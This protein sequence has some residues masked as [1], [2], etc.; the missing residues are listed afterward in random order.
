MSRSASDDDQRLI[1]AVFGVVFFGV[2]HDGMKIESLIP[3]VGDGPNRFL[4]ESLSHVNSQILT[5]QRRDF[6]NALGEKGYSEVFCFYETLKSPTAKQVRMLDNHLSVQ[7]TN[8]RQDK[9]GVWSMSG[10]LELFV[11]KSS[12]T[13][14]RSWESGPEHI[15]AIARTH[16]E[17]VRFRINDPQY[18]VVRQKLQ[19]LTR[20]ALPSQRPRRD[21]TV[22]CM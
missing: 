12:A 1:Q 6:E 21:P 10:P 18:N 5:V 19:G 3:M 15:C 9:Q 13:H 14:A 22:K 7:N 11:T 2:P 4:I 20:R 8:F 17:L 16:S